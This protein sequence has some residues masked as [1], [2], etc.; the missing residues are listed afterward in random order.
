MHRKSSNNNCPNCGAELKIRSIDYFGRTGIIIL[1]ILGLVLTSALW[2]VATT[3]TKGGNIG[4]ALVF[5]SVAIF[6]LI[7]KVS[8]KQR[9]VLACPNCES[10]NTTSEN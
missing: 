10:A 7:F 8:S 6:T 1:A 3:T 4:K 5:G 9:D 2:Y